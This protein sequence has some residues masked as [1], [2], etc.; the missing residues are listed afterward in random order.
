MVGQ[1]QP[2]RVATAGRRDPPDLTV[3]A[4]VGG[5]IDIE[6]AIG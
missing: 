6:M 3:G 2:L 4:A 1:P 5:S